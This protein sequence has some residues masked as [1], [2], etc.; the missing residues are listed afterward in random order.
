MLTDLFTSRLTELLFEESDD[1]IGIYD[2]GEERYIHVNQAGVRLLGFSSEEALLTDP[3]LSRSLRPQQL[4]GEHNR[5]LID[6]LIQV[7][8]HEELTQLQKKD[9]QSFWGKINIFTFLVQDRTYALIRL[10]DQG[11]LHRTERDLDNSIRR[12]EAIFSRATISIIVCNQQGLILSANQLT[13]QL[14]G[15]QPHELEN[16]SIDQLMPSVMSY[17]YEKLQQ[18]VTPNPGPPPVNCSCELQG[19]R[20]DDSLFPIELS[21]SHFYL[22]G[23]LYVAAFINDISFKKEAE[24]QLLEQKVQLER[25]NAELEQ[26]VVDR[27]HVLLNTLKQLETS[28][29]ELAQSLATER[30]LSE[31]KSRFVSMASHEFRTPLTAVLNSTT[32]IEKY[33]NTD[34]QDKR[35]KHLH[36]IRSSVKHLN[37]I[38]EE[39][40]SVGKLEE[41]KIKAH[42]SRVDFAKLVSEILADLRVA[43][44]PGQLIQTD[45][46][47]LSP[48]WLDGSLLRKIILNLLSNAVKYSGPGSVVNLHGNCLMG[49]L[50]VSIQDQGIG[51]STQDQQHLFEQFFRAR[52]VNHIPGTGLGLHIVGRY[53]ALM[54]GQIDLQ[55]ELNQGTTITLNLPYENDPLD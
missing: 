34:Q 26:K 23:E 21:L 47:C 27:T 19:K 51:I 17:Y 20:K 5:S 12:F 32:L 25:L 2:L 50:T 28:K 7:G 11:Q 10:I 1:F 6:R 22:D 4:E 40:L 41:G 14:S 42:P 54:G 37:E 53:V 38:L 49:Q 13:Y 33:T 48:I 36:R 9:S 8:H 24:R 30:E 15:Y 16:L 31:L 46:C 44:K 52:N 18:F 29:E 45:L 43:L 55:S 3:N 35:E 39:F